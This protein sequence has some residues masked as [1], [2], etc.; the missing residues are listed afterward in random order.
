MKYNPYFLAELCGLAY[1]NK[2]MHQDWENK[3][4]THFDS[5]QVYTD[6]QFFYD[7]ATD[8]QAYA[9]K[10][11]NLV[12]ICFPGT[13]DRKDFLTNL[14]ANISL[15]PT[16]QYHS[17]FWRAFCSIRPQIINYLNTHKPTEVITTGHSLGGAL[18]KIAALELNNVSNCITFGAPPISSVSIN[19]HPNL[20][21]TQ[22][23][24]EADIV[25]RIMFFGSETVPKII[26]YI[27]KKLSA[28]KGK[29][30]RFFLQ[31][32]KYI[33]KFFAKDLKEYGLLGDIKIID[34]S[35]VVHKLKEPESI[36]AIMKQAVSIDKTHMVFHHF[37]D[38]YKLRLKTQFEDLPFNLDEDTGRRAITPE[39]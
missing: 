3:L 8:T 13:Q 12:I 23:I 32:L 33:I 24:N 34:I 11:N 17:G 27:E 1:K 7:K 5:L 14:H 18:A 4:A 25:P 28:S 19:K 20:Q 6:L 39:F 38:V 15:E 36:N 37:I 29:V 21:I 30:I 22:F 31:L 2:L 16:K 10:F 35:G 26:F 9:I